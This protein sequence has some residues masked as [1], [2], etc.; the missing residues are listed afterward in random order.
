MSEIMPNNH[1]SG[2]KRHKRRI[3]RTALAWFFVIVVVLVVILTVVTIISAVGGHNLR[4]KASSA[5]PNLVV[6]ETEMQTEESAS[7]EEVEAVPVWKEG[8]VRHN[9]RIYEY[10][11]DILTFLVLGVD[12]KGTVKESETLTDGGQNDANFLVVVNP[13]DKKVS[14]LTI[15]RDTMTEINMYGMGENGENLVTYAQLAVQHG[16]GDGKE[17]SCELTRDTISALLYDLPIHG[18]VA[19]NMGAITKIND[20]IGGVELTVLED[21][22]KFRPGLT[23]G[24]KVT[25]MGEDAYVYVKGR[26]TSMFESNLGRL[27]R[28]KQY[29]AAFAAKL[30]EKVKEDITFPITLYNELSKYMVTD[31]TADEVVYLTG[32]LLDYNLDAETIYSLEGTTQ[33]GEKFEEFYPDKDALKDLMITLFYQEVKEGY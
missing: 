13:D 29:L 6:E 31:I 18:Y 33:M 10:N 4:D 15:N 32:E 20:A 24:A 3:T 27:A 2:E 22:T 25:L 28:Q 19:I 8:W 1:P 12:K 11:E 21:L 30:K 16:F 5:R 9:G 7:V 17:L 14:I 26:D 23:E